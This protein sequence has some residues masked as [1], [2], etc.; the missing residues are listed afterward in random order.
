M[1]KYYKQVIAG[2]LFFM[3]VMAVG[4]WRFDPL[5]RNEELFIPQGS[6]AFIDLDEGHKYFGLKYRT[7]DILITFNNGN[8]V[9][10]SNIALLK[11][12]ELHQQIIK[13]KNYESSCFKVNGICLYVSILGLFNYNKTII[14][15]MSESTIQAKVN[16]S[17]L[18]NTILL[19]NG[20]PGSINFPNILG[21]FKPYT[22]SSSGKYESTAIRI[23]Y[24]AIYADT[25]ESIY[26]TITSWEKEI[27]NLCEDKVDE[28][29]NA[30]L[31]LFY[32][33]ARTRDDAILES[34]VGDLPL[35]S[36]AFILMVLFCLL[37]FYRYDNPVTGHVVIGIAGIGVIMVGII[38][39]FGLAMWCGVQFVAFTGIL[40]FLILGIG[41]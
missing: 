13:L 1:T 24:Y 25:K 6:Q 15:N 9:L 22:A 19:E 28:F 18:D 3:V 17:Y 2:C 16:E 35:F 30:G 39:G 36:V 11:A 41:K 32:F 21:A 40:L 5:M 26:D 10:S 7:E 8:N 20:R 31:G 4:G 38:C 34:T 33:T 14:Q 12:L 37:V 29:N 27:L 23:T